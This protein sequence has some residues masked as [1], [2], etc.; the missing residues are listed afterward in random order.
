MKM[1]YMIIAF[2]FSTHKRGRKGWRGGED[3]Q[4]HYKHS[5]KFTFP[6]LHSRLLPI[7]VKWT[8]LSSLNGCLFAG[9]VMSWMIIF[10]SLICC[11][12]KKYSWSYAN[13]VNP[14]QTPHVSESVVPCRNY[15]SRHIWTK[16]LSEKN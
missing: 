2:T 16:F 5:L 11:S 3:L 9:Y 6:V 15:L 8:S 10:L 13:S 14:D 1:I 7:Y 4:Y 12:E